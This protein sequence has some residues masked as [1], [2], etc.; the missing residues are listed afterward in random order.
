MSQALAMLPSGFSEASSLPERPWRHL[1]G[2][3]PYWDCWRTWV[4]MSVPLTR[5]QPWPQWVKELEAQQLRW[6]CSLFIPFSSLSW[7]ETWRK[8]IASNSAFVFELKTWWCLG[9]MWGGERFHTFISLGEHTSIYL[10]KKKTTKTQRSK[11][12]TSLQLCSCSQGQQEV[13]RYFQQI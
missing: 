1:A 13:V 12:L 9:W 8:L 10:Q 11:G 4:E 2:F 3:Y 5:S 7:T 6:P